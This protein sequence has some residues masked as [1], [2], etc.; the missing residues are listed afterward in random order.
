MPQFM[1]M[2]IIAHYDSSWYNEFELVTIFQVMTHMQTYY[3]QQVKTDFLRTCNTN[4]L[5][6]FVI[7]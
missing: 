3:A 7:Q 4:K 5:I 2:K 6:V 1:R